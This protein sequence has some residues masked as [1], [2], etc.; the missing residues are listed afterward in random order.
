MLHWNVVVK[1][2]E[3]EI[4]RRIN[5]EVS[6]WR[7]LPYLVTNILPSSCYSQYNLSEGYLTNSYPPNYQ[8]SLLCCIIPSRILAFLTRS[9]L[10]IMKFFFNSHSSLAYYLPMFSFIIKSWKKQRKCVIIMPIASGLS[11][12]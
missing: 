10:L 4:W 8:V 5:T 12:S 6:F 1:N 9:L 3:R 2:K 11:F 7:F